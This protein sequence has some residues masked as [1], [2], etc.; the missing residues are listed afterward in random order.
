MYKR[1]SSGLSRAQFLLSL[2]WGA[3]GTARCQ[4]QNTLER[5]LQQRSAGEGLALL[6]IRNSWMN[7]LVGGN[8][9][10]RNPRGNS[11]AWFSAN[12]D[13]VAWWLLNAPPIVHAC[14]GLVAVTGRDGKLLWR[15]PGGFRSGPEL[16]QTLS[17]S[18]DGKRVA[19]YAA[20]VGDQDASIGP[21]SLSLQW[22]EIGNAKMVPIGDP[23][24][25]QGLVG[26]VSWAPDGKSLVFDRAGTIFIHQVAPQRTLR[27]ADGKDPTWSPDG[28]QISFRGHEGKAITINPTTLEM[29][30][31]LGTRTVLSPI[32]WSPDSRYVVVT[33]PAPLGEKL[34][35]LD[36][37][38]TALTKVYRLS[39]MSSMTVDT[40]NI[41]SLDD[42][43]RWL[44]WILDYPGFLRGAQ[45]DLQLRCNAQ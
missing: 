33:E 3:Q 22:G 13:F 11:L 38:V 40:I 43:G 17:L 5:E 21:K 36:P 29:R 26:S 34:S 25:E 20:Q 14:P 35:R 2:F 28:K 39:D 30:D 42:R 37:T 9:P 45:V 10:T 8:A 19:L 44:F 41:D 1:F 32:Q 4:L 15:L 6:R 31:L 18:R 7:V 23:S 27:V 24:R 12:G 16:L